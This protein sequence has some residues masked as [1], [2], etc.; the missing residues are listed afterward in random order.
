MV[1]VIAF[2]PEHMQRMRVQAC[3]RE[4][5]ALTPQAVFDSLVRLP[6]FTA[7]ADGEPL[8]CFGMVLIWPG[9]AI[10]WAYLAEGI[11]HRMTAVVR[12]MR[13]AIAEHQ[14]AR[15]EMDTQ[16]TFAEGHRLARLL[17]FHKEADGL[18]R[19]YPDGAAASLYVRIK[20]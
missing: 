13:R 17:G 6:S 8:G 14:P 3:Q 10:C 20:A 18:Q 16:A 4:M 12:A 5:W 1:E 19:Y 7:M 9:R 15:L 2:R 11:G